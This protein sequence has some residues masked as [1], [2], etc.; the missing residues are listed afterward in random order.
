MR[1]GGLDEIPVIIIHKHQKTFP[2]NVNF[3]KS[4]RFV[5]QKSSM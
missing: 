3:Q 4:E 5:K 2:N 1:A